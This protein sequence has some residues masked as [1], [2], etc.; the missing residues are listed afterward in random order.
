MAAAAATEGFTNARELYLW[1][2]KQL[3]STQV[4]LDFPFGALEDVQT[5]ASA[6]AGAPR[7]G[8]SSAG[9][10]GGDAAAATEPSSK[11]SITFG[12][13]SLEGTAAEAEASGPG[14]VESAQWQLSSAEGAAVSVRRAGDEGGSRKQARSDRMSQRATSVQ[15]GCHTKV[16]TVN[17]AFASAFLT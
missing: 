3:T 16:N 8:N 7:E 6:S 9:G 14:A 11:L 10:A 12:L 5:R 15:V 17:P 4:V 13:S 2:P 1:E